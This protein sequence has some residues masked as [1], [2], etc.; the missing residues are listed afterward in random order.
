MNFAFEIDWG[1]HVFFYVLVYRIFNNSLSLLRS[2][3]K[4]I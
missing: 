4:F 1:S 3:A 2:Q